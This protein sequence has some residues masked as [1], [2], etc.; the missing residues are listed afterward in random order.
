M[1][2]AGR[3]HVTRAGGGSIASRKVADALAIAVAYEDIECLGWASQVCDR[4]TGL[5]GSQCVASNSWRIGNLTQPDVFPR[6][7]EAATRADIIIVAAHEA[8]ELPPDLCAWIDAWLPRRGRR[9][10]TLLALLTAAPG[11]E[12]SSK[13]RHY[14]EAVAQRGALVF[15]AEC[16]N[17]A[18]A[19][20]RRGHLEAAAEG[21]QATPSTLGHI[22]VQGQAGYVAGV[23]T[24]EEDSP[25]TAERS[26]EPPG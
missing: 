5:I 12:V 8:H 3:N 9:E 11:S 4:V 1:H 13:A 26:S 22:P 23:S 10:G 14:L 17:P 21:A 2:D 6:A 19:P 15:V 20:V 18:A 7:I 16:R 24:T 25:S